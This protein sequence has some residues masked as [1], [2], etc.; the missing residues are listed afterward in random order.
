[1]SPPTKEERIVTDV[2]GRAKVA[3]GYDA[4]TGS[5]DPRD[6]NSSKTSSSSR[7][8][9]GRNTYGSNGKCENKPF[10]KQSEAQKDLFLRVD[11]LKLHGE[12]KFNQNCSSIFRVRSTRSQ[13]PRAGRVT[14][15]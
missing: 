12:C 1:M 7:P 13:P 8:T 14:S 9:R 15:L 5:R 10:E 4:R 11:G 3:V 6:D 2:K